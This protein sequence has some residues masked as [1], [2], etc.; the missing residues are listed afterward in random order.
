MKLKISKL[1]QQLIY[2]NMPKK[3]KSIVYRVTTDR[4]SID[5]NIITFWCNEKIPE[6]EN[7][8]LGFKTIRGYTFDY[9]H[10]YWDILTYKYKDRVIN[11]GQ[12]SIRTRYALIDKICRFNPAT[13]G[14]TYNS[15]TN[16]LII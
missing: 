9:R 15:N 3:I 13:G 5:N 2:K 12:K 7:I 8:Y 6:L 1:K 11:N 14:G 4:Y 10:D 16:Q